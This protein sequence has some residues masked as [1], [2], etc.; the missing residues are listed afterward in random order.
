MSTSSFASRLATA[1]IAAMTTSTLA[2]AALLLP[3]VTTITAP[4]ARPRTADDPDSL[5]AAIERRIAAVPG[6]VVA[7]AW[8]DPATGD[9]LDIA[10]DTVFHAASTMK[11]PVMIELFRRHEAGALS[12]DQEVLLVNEFASIV[13]GS[14]YALDAGDDSDSALYARVGTRVPVRELM[15]RMIDRSS[16]LAT[17]ALIALVG[18]PSVTATA[19]ALGAPG[20]HVRR[21][22]EDGKAYDAGLNNTT[23]ARAL[24]ALMRAIEEGRAGSATST[25]EMRTTLLG[26]QF[27]D[28]IPAGLPPGTPVAHKTG[29]ITGIRH[30]AAIVYPPGRPPYVLVVLTRGI[31]D[32]ATARRLIADISRMVWET[33]TGAP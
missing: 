10:A 3:A 25:A 29:S 12:L 24:A 9:S 20:M 19:R 14:R 18:A 32:P 6:A 26:Q 23:T 27:D 16:N 8:R 2:L 31:A 30:D 15:R 4:S 21:G 1:D 28:E 33:A 13:D 22:V 5:R 17:N 11:V 7:V